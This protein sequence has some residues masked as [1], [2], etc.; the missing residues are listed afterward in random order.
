MASKLVIVML[1]LRS[2]KYLQICLMKLNLIVLNIH[3]S[4]TENSLAK[5]MRQLAKNEK[6]MRLFSKGEQDAIIEAAKGSD[7]KQTLKFVGRFAPTSTVS[8]LP[9]IAL[10]AGDMFTGGAFAGATTLGRMG[11]T[12]MGEGAITDLARFMRSG[13]PNRYETTPRNLNPKNY[14]CRSMVFLKVCCQ[15]TLLTQRTRYNE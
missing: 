4:G 1:N 3:K 14:W 10:G 15:T 13:L 8:A 2:L 7:L 9:T 5:Q 11:A 6:R 12:K